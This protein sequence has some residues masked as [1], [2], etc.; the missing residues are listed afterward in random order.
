M[1][2]CISLLTTGSATLSAFT[3]GSGSTLF[4]S[5]SP[6]S[7]LCPVELAILELFR[8]CCITLFNE[9]LFVFDAEEDDDEVVE[10]EEEPSSPTARGA[11]GGVIAGVLLVSSL[12]TCFNDP[13]RFAST[14]LANKLGLLLV[15]E[16]GIGISAAD[17]VPGRPSPIDYS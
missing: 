6:S 1:I 15:S 8:R 10:E 3:S 2:D 5:S 11:G 13:D 4:S 14:S 9:N 7:L 12:S 17:D 16:V